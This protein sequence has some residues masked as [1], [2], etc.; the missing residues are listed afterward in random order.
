LIGWAAASEETVLVPD[1]SAD[2]RYIP[3][4]DSAGT[5]SELVVPLR[6]GDTVLGVLD[7]QSECRQTFTE[8]DRTVLES[9]AAQATIA[10]ENARLAQ[11]SQ[12]MAVLEERTR[13]ARDLHDAVSQ[14]L[15]SAGLIAEVLPGLWR[16]N[17]AEGRRSL[18]RL[19]QL[20]HGALA[21]LACCR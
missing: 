1:V 3:L 21:E 10:I 11:R 6:A 5:C 8:T 7:V 16:N 18:V 4:P 13:I 9:L 19:Q 2:A 14:T 12:Q 17:R 20:T 15:W